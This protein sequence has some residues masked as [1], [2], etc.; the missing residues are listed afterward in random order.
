LLSSALHADVREVGTKAPPIDLQQILQAPPGA[1]A[2]LEN[3]RGKVVVIEFWATWCV[4]CIEAIPHFNELA[5]SM[6]DDA[7][8][9][10]AVTNEGAEK[11]VPFL[12]KTPIHGWVGLN[13]T[14]SM[15]NSYGINDESGWPLTVVIRPDGTVDARLRPFPTIAFPLTKHNLQN[16]IDG[17]PSGLVSHRI[18]FAGDVVDSL[19]RPVADAFIHALEVTGKDTWRE[20]S[21][22]TTDSK[23]KY[24]IDL[25]Y[26]PAYF[27]GHP[28]VLEITGK[29]YRTIRTE[30][31]R[32]LPATS[33][34]IRHIT[35]EKVE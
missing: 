21:K 5:D 15:L 34:V 3:L 17:K 18:R 24:H 19:G 29:G 10:I 33:P 1:T 14:G 27:A 22:A 25:E 6:K 20:I 13:T 32:P 7:V 35:L 28:N 8:V 30:D 26:P 23:G 31:L 9:F 4:H 2:T 12:K 16:L 11:V